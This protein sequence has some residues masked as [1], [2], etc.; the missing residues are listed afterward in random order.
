LRLRRGLGTKEERALIVK[1]LRPL[2]RTGVGGDVLEVFRG[3]AQRGRPATVTKAATGFQ[4][5]MESLESREVDERIA[6]RFR[7]AVA[8]EP[9]LKDSF[10]RTEA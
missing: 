1:L 8:R 9:E 3:T 7:A 5:S 10:P 4:D 6:H 2:W